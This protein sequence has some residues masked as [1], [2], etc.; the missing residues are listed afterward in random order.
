MT[1][2]VVFGFLYIFFS[3]GCFS[4]SFSKSFFFSS[5]FWGTRDIDSM[6]V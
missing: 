2:L 5:L 1:T 6:A 3:S 4:L